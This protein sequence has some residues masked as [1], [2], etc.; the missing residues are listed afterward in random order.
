MA[1]TV[2]SQARAGQT[3]Q[4]LLKDALDTGAES[5]RMHWLENVVGCAASQRG[6][7]SL[8][9]GISRYHDDSRLW[10]ALVDLRN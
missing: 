1:V 5:V 4:P 2:A 8:D 9:V 10:R 3:F 7:R 6:N